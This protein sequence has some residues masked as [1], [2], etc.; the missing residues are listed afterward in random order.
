M[1]NRWK[2]ATTLLIMIGGFVGWIMN[3]FFKG[4]A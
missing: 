2:G 1:T 4:H 3:F